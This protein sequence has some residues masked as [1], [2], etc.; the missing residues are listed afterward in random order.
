MDNKSVS[1]KRG[2]IVD[3]STDQNKR[4]Y[5]ELLRKPENRC[6][7]P[8]NSFAEYAPEPNPETKKKAIDDTAA[9]AASAGRCCHP[10]PTTDALAKR[11]LLMDEWAAYC[12][13]ERR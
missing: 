8:F 12:M 5:Y 7:V 9:L 4:D 13:S 11:R 2:E 1:S 6:L 3:R 10:C